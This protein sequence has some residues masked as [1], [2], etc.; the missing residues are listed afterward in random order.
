[1]NTFI[2]VALFAIGVVLLAALIGGAGLL[3][4]RI[5]RGPKQ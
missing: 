1:V 4:W 5:V 2:A 3:W